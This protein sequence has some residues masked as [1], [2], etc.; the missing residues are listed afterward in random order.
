MS[1]TT[2]LWLGLLPAA[3]H[4]IIN[5]PPSPP[6][7]I[8]ASRVPLST[9]LSKLPP[10]VLSGYEFCK[11]R[12]FVEKSLLC[13]S[14]FCASFNLPSPSFGKTIAFPFTFSST[15]TINLQYFLQKKCN[16]RCLVVCSFICH[17]WFGQQAESL[18]LCCRPPHRSRLLPSPHPQH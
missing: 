3:R 11:Q 1:F 17:T 9:S 15:K 10:F 18:P 4:T 7:L 5:L 13:G 8:L 6:L 2:S 12:T 14:H 16:F